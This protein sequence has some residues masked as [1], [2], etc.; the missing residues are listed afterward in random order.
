M[1]RHLTLAEVPFSRQAS[2]Q[3][4][5]YTFKRSFLLKKE[6]KGIPPNSIIDIDMLHICKG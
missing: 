3:A 5:Q 2:R 4:K 6:L 1:L